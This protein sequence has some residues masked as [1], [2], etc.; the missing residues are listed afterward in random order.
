MWK[1]TSH[2]WPTLMGSEPSRES[3][4]VQPVH[5]MRCEHP[6]LTHTPYSP[7]MRRGS[8]VKRSEVRL[9]GRRQSRRC[10]LQQG[11]GHMVYHSRSCESLSRLCLKLKHPGICRTHRMFNKT[12]LK[13]SNLQLANKLRWVGVWLWHWKFWKWVTKCEAVQQVI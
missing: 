6:P 9:R 7:C 13:V 12:K 5:L 2:W 10:A 4:I 1:H 3:L 8:K 11:R